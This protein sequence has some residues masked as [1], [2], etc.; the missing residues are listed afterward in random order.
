MIILAPKPLELEVPWTCPKCHLTYMVYPSLFK[1]DRDHLCEFKLSGLRIA[2]FFY[3]LTDD[4]F[5]GEFCV[6]NYYADMDQRMETKVPDGSIQLWERRIEGDLMVFHA[7][8]GYDGGPVGWK[9][10]RRKQVGEHLPWKQ[11]HRYALSSRHSMV[12]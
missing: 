9:Y 5:I 3:R 7:P 10:D 12:K 1:W 8:D 6:A 2:Y 4:N 11:M